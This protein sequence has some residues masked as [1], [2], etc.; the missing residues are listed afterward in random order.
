MHK[1]PCT[2]EGSKQSLEGRDS[3][4][5][6]REGK[7][8]KPPRNPKYEQAMVDS[9]SVVS[10]RRRRDTTERHHNTPA[11]HV[12]RSLVYDN[13]TVDSHASQRREYA[14]QHVAWAP[15]TWYTRWSLSALHESVEC[16]SESTTTPPPQTGRN[17][18]RKQA[19]NGPEKRLLLLASYFRPT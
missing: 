5:Y 18:H 9:S 8:I 6:E 7:H 1:E 16:I 15:N 3:A 2:E 19:T 10:R 17:K 11:Q 12:K 4:A 13:K 14:A